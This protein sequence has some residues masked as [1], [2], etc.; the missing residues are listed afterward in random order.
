MDVHKCT[1]FYSA[2]TFLIRK[3][4]GSWNSTLDMKCSLS[5][6]LFLPCSCW[7]QVT[8]LSVPLATLFKAVAT[9]KKV[10]AVSLPHPLWNS[11]VAM[12]IM[13]C[14]LMLFHV[15][16]GRI[17]RQWLLVDFSRCS[18]QRWLNR[19]TYTGKVNFIKPHESSE[20]RAHTN[21]FT[22]IGCL[23]K[24]LELWNWL[25][26]YSQNLR[27]LTS[28]LNHVSLFSMFAYEIVSSEMDG[29]RKWQ[30]WSFCASPNYRLDTVRW[31]CD[32]EVKHQLGCWITWSGRYLLGPRPLG[33]FSLYHLT[34]PFSKHEIS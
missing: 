25:Q 12:K 29:P 31:Q 32:Q 22:W 28:T 3:G 27:H 20:M 8:V 26:S 30:V 34:I 23:S 14:S 24:L 4:R 17:S 1:V 21:L 5:C 6:F 16:L 2:P 10:H 11:L 33:S 15:K 13:A 9:K 19:L 18:S 7:H